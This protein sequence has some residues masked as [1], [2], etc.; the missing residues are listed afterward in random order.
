M[1]RPIPTPKSWVSTCTD[2]A[3]LP[4]GTV[5]R[6]AGVGL[7]EVL[8][9]VLVLSI[10]F[11]GIAALQALSMSTNNSAMARSMA[12][13][14]SYSI[15]DAMRADA[16]SARGGAYNGTVTASACPP[17][18]ATASLSNAQLI[19]WC[20]QLGGLGATASTTG[21]INCKPTGACVITITF[22]DSR[23]G[24]GGSSGQTII[25]TAML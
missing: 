2:R 17:A 18:A 8:V 15:M 22:D 21:A 6:Q 4:S 25:T 14:D 12:T 5:N 9:A 13:I 7:I 19:Q 16:A 24:A 23:A 10:A 20:G 11:L 1:N 3:R